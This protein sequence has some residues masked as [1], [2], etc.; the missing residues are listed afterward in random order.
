MI[1][2]DICGGQQDK[3]SFSFTISKAPSDFR[4]YT[5]CCETCFKKALSIEDLDIPEDKRKT[6]MRSEKINKDSRR[7]ERVGGVITIVNL[8][9]VLIFQILYWLPRITGR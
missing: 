4:S 1:V 2:C 6:L 5:C 8:L 9:A 3:E 7:I